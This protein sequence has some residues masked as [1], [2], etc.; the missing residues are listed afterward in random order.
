MINN[1]AVGTTPTFQCTLPEGYDIRGAAVWLTIAQK[2]YS[3][4]L[5][6]T[7]DRLLLDDNVISVFLTQADTLRLVA[8]KPAVIQL[9]WVFEGNARG[10][11]D[12]VPLQF[13]DNL[14]KRALAFEPRF[15]PRSSAEVVA[16]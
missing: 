2:Q 12:E 1:T 6:I 15:V 3:R 13:D 10:C 16:I 14:I 11:T 9:N 4:E 8:N 7:G 5:E